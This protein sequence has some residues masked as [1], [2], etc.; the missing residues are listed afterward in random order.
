MKNLVISERDGGDGS[1]G[2]TGELRSDRSQRTGAANVPGDVGDADY[3]PDSRVGAHNAG[4]TLRNHLRDTG[5]S[6]LGRHRN[7]Q[8]RVSAQRGREEALL[9]ALA[10]GSSAGNRHRYANPE[11][12]IND[13]AVI[14]IILDPLYLY[15]DLTLLL[16]FSIIY[17]MIIYCN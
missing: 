2:D 9:D 15:I 10:L 8:G 4:H 11:Y 7:G 17:Y 5:H 3:T 14:Y 16:L 12:D 13:F 6:E 1:G